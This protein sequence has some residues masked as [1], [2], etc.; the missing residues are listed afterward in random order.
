M[1]YHSTGPPRKLAIKALCRTI[2]ASK[3]KWA[4]N[5]LHHTTSD[6]LWEA[7]AWHKGRSIK[8]IPPLLIAPEHVSDNTLEM[9]EA[10]KDRFFVTAGPHVHPSQP[11]DPAPL[12]THSLPPIT[13]EEIASALASTSNKSAPG[14]SGIPYQLIKWAFRSWPD[15]FLDIFN[16]SISLG[17]HLWSDALVVV[18]PK[19]AKP[20]YCLPKAYRPISLLKCCGKL[21]EKIIAKRVLHDSHH[22]DILPN[23]QFG[24]CNYHCATD[25]ALCLVHNAQATVWAGST[26][27]VVLFDIQGF[28][29][30]INIDHIVHIFLNL[31]FPTSLCSWL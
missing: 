31:G 18:I 30:N 27:S 5:F 20:D 16:A 28:F 4:H 9:T 22:Y 11:D 8:R 7:A 25:A 1:V 23:T 2:A 24:S 3:H 19:L 29:D 10:L 21:L 12:P 17:H 13:Q 6:N 26:A 14:L 15:C